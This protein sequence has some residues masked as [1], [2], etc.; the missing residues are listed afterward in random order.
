M[1]THFYLT[2][3][4]SAEFL[5][6]SRETVRRAV[7]AGALAAFRAPGLRSHLR[8]RLADLEQYRRPVV[9]GTAAVVEHEARP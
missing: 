2:I 1:V 4:E 5:D 6:V 9:T 8:I 3:G 7:K